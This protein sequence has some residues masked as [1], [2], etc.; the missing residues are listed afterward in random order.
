MNSARREK[1]TRA[2]LSGSSLSYKRVFRPLGSH[3]AFPF[4]KLKRKTVGERESKEK[5]KP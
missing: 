3:F 1:R 4:P 5:R 2:I